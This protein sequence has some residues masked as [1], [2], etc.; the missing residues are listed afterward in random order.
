VDGDKGVEWIPMV[1]VHELSMGSHEHNSLSGSINGEHFLTRCV[2]L[3]YKDS[4]PWSNLFLGT[5]MDRLHT[6][7]SLDAVC[8]PVVCDRGTV[9]QIPR[10]C[11]INH[12]EC[13]TFI[14][15]IN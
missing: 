10:P 8:L 9:L 1:G 5:E 11:I 2:T 14:S 12:D 6:A 4:A 3:L 15:L 13:K 7:A